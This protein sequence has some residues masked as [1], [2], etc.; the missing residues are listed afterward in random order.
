MTAFRRFAPALGLLAAV[1]ALLMPSASSAALAPPG[2]FGVHPRSLADADAADYERMGEANVGVI[3]TGF[4]FGRA[5]AHANDPYD[6]SDFDRIVG[7]AAANGIDVIPVLLGVPP[8]VST[9]PGATPLGNSESDWRDYLKASSRATAP[10]GSSGPSTP[11]SP[12]T[13]SR[14]GRSGTR[15]TR[16]PTGSSIRSRASTAGC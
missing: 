16:S 9:N 8:Y 3:R 15:R 1:A 2:F 14:T 7:G 5:K 6:W 13:R 12:L 4:V 11:T 10:M